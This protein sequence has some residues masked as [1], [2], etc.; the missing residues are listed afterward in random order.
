MKNFNL[1]VRM[2]N[3][4]FWIQ[5][6]GAGLLAALS[7]NNMKPADLTTW[8]GVFDLLS[9]IVMNP[10]LLGMVLWNVWSAANDPTTAGTGD[11][12]N[13]L[14]YETPKNAKENKKLE[15]NK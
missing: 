1:K 6:L 12:T 2:K 9:G 4:I 15:E 5:V 10:F 8:Q 3:P 7:Y 11:S 14:A 13:A